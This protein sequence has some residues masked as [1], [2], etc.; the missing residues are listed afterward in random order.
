MTDPRSLDSESS[1][2][3]NE[4]LSTLP[5]KHREILILRLVVGMSEEETAPAVG[6]PRELSAWLNTSHRG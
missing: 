2:Q 4:L 6:V 1:R 3:S 5:D